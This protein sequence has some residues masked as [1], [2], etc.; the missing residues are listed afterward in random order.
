MRQIVESIKAFGFCAPVLVDENFALLAG[1]G[2]VEA[3]RQL[4]MAEIPAVQLLGLSEAEK[5]AFALADNKIGD[6]AGWDFTRLTIELSELA[7]LLKQEN[8][9]IALTGFSSSE[10]RELQITFEK[11]RARPGDKIDRSACPC[12]GPRSSGACRCR[13]PASGLIATEVER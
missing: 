10:V 7:E 9:D 1:H 4:E 2:R 3:A 8:L 6:N 5:R 13:C 12:H 11:G